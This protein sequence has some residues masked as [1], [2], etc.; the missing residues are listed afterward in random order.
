MQFT[1]DMHRH[2]VTDRSLEHSVPCIFYFY[3]LLFVSLSP[4]TKGFTIY[5]S[6]LGTSVYSNSIEIEP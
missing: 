3:F 1:G 6:T 4:S 2:L 5:L